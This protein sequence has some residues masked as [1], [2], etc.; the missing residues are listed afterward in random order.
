MREVFPNVYIYSSTQGGVN[1]K[2]T[3]RD[4]Y[5]VIGALQPLDLKDLGER[6]DELEVAFEGS[7][8]EPKHLT[9]LEEKAK[10]IVLTDDYAPVENLL[11]VVVR[12]R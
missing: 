10:G 2:P 7:L 11:E 9:W 12:R 1:D 6:E 8:L 4:T 3:G 5:I